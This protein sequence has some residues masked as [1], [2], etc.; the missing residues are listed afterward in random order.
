MRRRIL[1]GLLIGF[2]LVS[3]ASMAGFAA[4]SIQRNEAGTG[5]AAGQIPNDV[6]M[7]RDFAAFADVPRAQ[8]S[9]QASAVLPRV[10]TMIVAL[11]RPAASVAGAKQ[12]S[13]ILEQQHVFRI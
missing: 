11:Q 2:F 3:A 7:D 1:T 12:A 6:R 9:S 8:I 4:G 13:A 5:P 10:V